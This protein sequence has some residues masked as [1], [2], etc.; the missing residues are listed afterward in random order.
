MVAACEALVAPTP[1]SRSTRS[2]KTQD[3]TS[4]TEARIDENSLENQ[5]PPTP[6]SHGI[7]ESSSARRTAEPTSQTDGDVKTKMYFQ[8][9][10]Y[11]YIGL[12]FGVAVILG[13][14]VGSWLDR[15]FGTG[16]WLTMA[17]VLF[18]V[19][20]GFNELIR[21]ARKYQR[22]LSQNRKSP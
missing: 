3:A 15:R 13:F 1:D 6:S 18:G 2:L 5:H 14:A 16:S 21:L 17:G 20:S 22:E 10:R 8:S 7:D 19:A 12:F 11:S 9:L 4:Q